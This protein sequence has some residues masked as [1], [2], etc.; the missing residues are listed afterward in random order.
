MFLEVFI[1]EKSGE[2]GESKGWRT[3]RASRKNVTGKRAEGR[4]RKKKDE[5]LER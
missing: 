1:Q 3:G 5:G 4:G 2:E